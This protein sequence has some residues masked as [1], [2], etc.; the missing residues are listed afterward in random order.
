MIRFFIISSILI[1]ALTFLVYFNT[2]NGFFT[3]DDYGPLGGVRNASFIE[4]IKND[5][6]KKGDI[7][8]RP[9]SDI[10]WKLDYLIWQFNPF[11]Y[12][13][14]NTALHALTSVLVFI[15]TFLLIRDRLVSLFA[16]ILF[17]VHPLHPE[18]VVR[19]A[20][21]YD[22][23]CAFFYLL[24][25]VTFIIYSNTSKKKYSYI[26]SILSYP[27]ALLSKETAITLPF[28]LVLWG[29]IFKRRRKRL[30]LYIPY[31]IITLIYLTIRFICIGDVGGYR[32]FE[33][34]P[35][36]LQFGF[37][38]FLKKM[39]YNIPMSFVLPMHQEVIKQEVRA[40]IIIIFF[41]G[42]AFALY[43]NRRQ[44]NK[45]LLLFWVS[46]I[47]INLIPIYNIV[48]VGQDLQGARLMYLPSLGFCI[49][50]AH[51][52][53]GNNKT[54]AAIK[55]INLSITILFSLLYAFI[56]FENNQPWNMAGRITGQI[57]KIVKEYSH[58]FSNGIK[59]YFFIPDTIQG[60]SPYGHYIPETLA[61]LILPVKPEEVVVI[62]DL[63]YG[64]TGEYLFYNFDL[65]QTD[66]RSSLGKRSFFLKWNEATELLEDIS[67]SLKSKLNN[68]RQNTILPKTYHFTDS[69][70]IIKDV[71]IPIVTIGA[72]ELK[73]RIKSK[74][75]K[76]VR[77]EI[78]WLS[79]KDRK[80]DFRKH[81]YFPIQIDGESHIYHIPFY[82]FNPDWLDEVYLEELR[83]QPEE[84]CDLEADYIRLLP[85]LK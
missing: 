14:T 55:K 63:N 68:P 32:D 69:S 5:L 12:H 52:L 21:R 38:T 9:V 4:I 44:M 36:F 6:P 77:L 37:S 57:P 28:I 73:M 3:S 45:S 66:L 33:G 25:L 15:L 2:L 83:F 54:G 11:G 81:I 20:D 31:F 40:L 76:R 23:L 46:F 51:S 61:P 42:I 43:F 1:F 72:I 29:F 18:A 79:N 78:F 30:K 7:F 24:S 64:D 47:M 84:A 70:L 35:L 27:L 41:I 22:L 60:T 56:T 67:V 74:K 80:W 59:F 34:R 53:L 58:R 71:H 85:F 10:L 19:L 82:L 75:S 48:W 13:F 39:V 26:I 16:G 8:I 17:S 50:F 62:S 49:V 65:R